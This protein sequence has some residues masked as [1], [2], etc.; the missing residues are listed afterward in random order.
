MVKV[1]FCGAIENN[2]ALLEEKVKT[3]QSSSHGP[4]DALLCCGLGREVNDTMEN[5]VDLPIFTRICANPLLQRALPDNIVFLPALEIVTFNDLTAVYIPADAHEKFP[6][7][8][9]AL[10]KA[11]KDVGYKGVDIMISD[12]MPASI[13]NG[14]SM[15]YITYVKSL[16]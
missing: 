5:K 8:V 4:F 10:L 6:S 11:T 16:H 2:W 14:L 1:L 7:E 15:K 13:E 3:L 12:D 9:D